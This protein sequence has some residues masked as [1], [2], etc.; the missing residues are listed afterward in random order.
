MQARV[1]I[2]GFKQDLVFLDHVELVT[3]E[4]RLEELRKLALALWGGAVPVQGTCGPDL[5]GLWTLYKDV[6]SDPSL[7]WTGDSDPAINPL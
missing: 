3:L 4:Q 1:G 6:I 5:G 2:G 7:V